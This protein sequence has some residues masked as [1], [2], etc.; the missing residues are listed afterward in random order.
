MVGMIAQMTPTGSAIYVTPVMGS[1]LITPHGLNMIHI[2]GHIF[3]GKQ[4]FDRLILKHAAAGLVHSS[5]RQYAVL[6]QPG[7]TA[8]GHDKVYR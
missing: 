3:T 2:I 7:N 5:L 8:L 4:V 1:S 6:I